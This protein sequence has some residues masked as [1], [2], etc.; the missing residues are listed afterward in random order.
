MAPREIQAPSR[1]GHVP[2]RR[3]QR[4]THEFPLVA[5][6]AFLES[7]AVVP[8]LTHRARLETEMVRLDLRNSLRGGADRGGFDSMRE[9]TDVARPIRRCERSNGARRELGKTQ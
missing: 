7:V 6:G 2:T 4:R 1:L 5:T 9:L 3:V 8:A